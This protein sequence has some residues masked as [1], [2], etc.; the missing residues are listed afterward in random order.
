MSSEILSYLVAACMGLGL[1]AAA[2]FRIFV[3]LLFSGLAL[4]FGIG[5]AA[6]LVHLGTQ[7]GVV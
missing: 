2:G 1:A 5:P 3:C 7:L 6:D 4:R